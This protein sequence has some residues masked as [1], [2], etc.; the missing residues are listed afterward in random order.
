MPHTVKT[1]IAQ[2]IYSV[3]VVT[4]CQNTGIKKPVTGRHWFLCRLNL[5]IQKITLQ[6]SLRS[7]LQ[8]LLALR[9]YHLQIG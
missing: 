4:L 8:L 5:D 9:Y 6:N 2:H 1:V 3:Y 7:R